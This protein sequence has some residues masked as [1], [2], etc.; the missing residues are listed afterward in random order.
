MLAGMLKP[1]VLL[2]IAALLA[3]G[4]ST[5]AA[6]TPVAPATSGPTASAA[7]TPPGLPGPTTAAVTEGP[8]ATFGPDYTGD[9][10]GE[11]LAGT[12]KYCGSTANPYWAV[13]V[14]GGDGSH[15]FVAYDIPAGSTAA[16]AA[17]VVTPFVSDEF[18]AEL[19]G[20]GQFVPGDPPHFIIVN[21]EGTYDI[22]LMV[23]SFC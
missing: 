15:A 9:W 16:V 12:V 18:T 10:G 14:A 13:D 7:A 4:C 1:L 5:P 22:V 20:T 8:A 17:E 6:S 2:T 21:G 23:G 11:R 19:A 3:I